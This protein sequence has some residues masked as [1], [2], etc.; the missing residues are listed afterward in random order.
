MPEL[1]AL[2]SERNRTW[3][4]LFTCLGLAFLTLTGFAI[5]N[6]VERVNI[7]YEDQ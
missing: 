2:L 6:A 3:T 4:L 5:G 1:L 7:A